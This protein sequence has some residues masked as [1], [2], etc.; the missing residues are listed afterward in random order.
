[1]YGALNLLLE[2]TGCLSTT[3][4]SGSERNASSGTRSWGSQPISWSPCSNENPQT[5]DAPQPPPASCSPAA[6]PAASSSCVD[7]LRH[8]TFRELLHRER[9]ISCLPACL[10]AGYRANHSRLAYRCAIPDVVPQDLRPR[11]GLQFSCIWLNFGQEY[12]T[13]APL[14]PSAFHAK[15]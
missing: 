10:F 11:S 7:E 1:M 13:A 6:T 12:A 14:K 2:Q 5:S 9:E 8:S 3:C 4:R 15:R